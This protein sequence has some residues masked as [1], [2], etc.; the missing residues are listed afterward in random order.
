MRRFASRVQVHQRDLV[1]VLQR[2]SRRV[3]ELRTE[4]P[5]VEDDAGV[6]KLLCRGAPHIAAQGRRGDARAVVGPRGGP[7][8]GAAGCPGLT[9]GLPSAH[10]GPGN[11]NRRSAGQRCRPPTSADWE[12]PGVPS[13]SAGPG[14]NMPFNAPKPVSD[15]SLPRGTTQRRG[16]QQRRAAPQAAGQPQNQRC[17]ARHATRMDFDAPWQHALGPG[18]HYYTPFQESVSASCFRNTA[19]PTKRHVQQHVTEVPVPVLY[20]SFCEGKQSSTEVVRPRP[21][22]VPVDGA[23]CCPHD[24]GTFRGH[25]GRFGTT[26]SGAGAALDKLVLSR[27]RRPSAGRPSRRAGMPLERRYHRANG[28]PRRS[29]TTP[30]ATTT[31][32]GG[33]T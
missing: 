27:R 1:H 2:I 12:A 29:P 31:P 33:T 32:G 11:A 21:R 3:L 16:S 22:G 8:G 25:H 5:H 26:E 18:G 19:V 4:G 14:N 28:A 6:H 7:S 17:A 30:R 10:H 9:C 20:P 13:R 15:A 24:D 23:L